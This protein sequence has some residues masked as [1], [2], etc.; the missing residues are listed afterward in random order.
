MKEIC[1]RLKKGEVNR[2]RWFVHDQVIKDNKVDKELLTALMD[3]RERDMIE[4]V[5]RIKEEKK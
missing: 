4:E 5:K 3:T 1:I 2:L